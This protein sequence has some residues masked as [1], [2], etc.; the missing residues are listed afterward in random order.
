LWFL[1]ARAASGDAGDVVSAGALD[2]VV[3]RLGHVADWIVIDAPPLAAASGGQQLLSV[4]TAVLIVVRFARTPRD[5]LRDCLRKL[6]RNPRVRVGIV[7]N[8]IAEGRKAAFTP[9]DP[10]YYRHLMAD[11]YR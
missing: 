10:E 9:A 7:L 11:Y 5:L 8:D 1:A 3:A 4:A 6:P 2:A